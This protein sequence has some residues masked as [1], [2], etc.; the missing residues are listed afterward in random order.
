MA[1]VRTRRRANP[2]FKTKQESKIERCLDLAEKNEKLSDQTFSHAKKMASAIPFGQPILVGHHSEKRDRR[3]RARIE[4]SFN[5]SIEQQKKSEYYKNK[6]ESIGTSGILSDDPEALIKLNKKLEVMEKRRET[7]KAFNREQKKTNTNEAVKKFKNELRA[8]DISTLTH[9]GDLCGNFSGWPLTNLGAKIRDCKKRIE[10]IKKM[11]SM[12]EINSIIN[13][14]E[15]KE[16]D[17]YI[18]VYFPGKPNEETRAKIKGYGIALKWSRYKSCWTRKKTASTG[19]Y[20]LEDL[21]T[22]LEKAG[23]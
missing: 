10:Q 7:Y 11:D 15:V 5:K 22:V 13:D 18:N 14:I 23:Y 2:D 20:F 16:E 9:R 4:N 1:D 12:P 21:K 19:K 6:A 8:R 17:G 3:Y